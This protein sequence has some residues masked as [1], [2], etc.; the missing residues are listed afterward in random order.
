MARE[1]SARNTERARQATDEKKNPFKDKETAVAANL[2]GEVA[3]EE[4]WIK[5]RLETR[6]MFLRSY[7]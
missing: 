5:G 3:E 2:W 1:N 6:S 4:E 7:D